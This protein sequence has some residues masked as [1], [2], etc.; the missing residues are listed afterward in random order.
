MLHKSRELIYSLVAILFITIVYLFMVAFGRGTPA[1][2]S[3][4]GH[5]MGILGFLLMVITETLYPLRKRM[6]NARWGR[7]SSWLEFHIF[8][9]LVGPYLVLL[10]T[11]WQFN[12]LAGVLS[13]LTLMIVLSGFVGRYIYTA[14]PRTPDGVELSLAEMNAQIRQLEDLLAEKRSLPRPTA[15]AP[16]SLAGAV[17]GRLGWG[18]PN[19]PSARR[20]RR[21]ANPLAAA[22]AAELKSLLRQRD[23]LKRQ[24][25]SLASARRMLSIWHAIHIPLGLTLFAMAI[26]HIVGAVYYAG[27]IK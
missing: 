24:V 17:V 1:A 26:V 5:S 8:T 22:Q 15:D 20:F 12:G 21:P 6:Q 2:S 11:S 7:M 18:L 3:L 16:A 19:G 14:V 9:G 25:G 27:M 4:Y 10:H 23:Q 13:L